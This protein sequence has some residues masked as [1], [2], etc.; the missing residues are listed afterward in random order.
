MTVYVKLRL[1]PDSL[2]PK[3]ALM[4]ILPHRLGTSEDVGKQKVRVPTSVS[5]LVGGNSH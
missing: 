3:S 4:S 1:D 2:A 5:G